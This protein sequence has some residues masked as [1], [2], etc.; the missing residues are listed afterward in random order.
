MWQRRACTGPCGDISPSAATLHPIALASPTC[1][2]NLISH[3]HKHSEY[4]FSFVRFIL[5]SNS[6]TSVA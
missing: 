6:T 1:I 2:V 4:T 5:V 3:V